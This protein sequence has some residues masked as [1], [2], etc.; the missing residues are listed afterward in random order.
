[1]NSMIQMKA[2]YE[3]DMKK[4]SGEISRYKDLLDQNQID[5][6][7]GIEETASKAEIDKRN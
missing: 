4:L 1:M 5:K 7:K 2:T 6:V 3:I